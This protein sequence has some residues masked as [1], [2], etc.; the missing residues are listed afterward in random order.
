MK[1][2]VERI[3]IVG[4]ALSFKS[5]ELCVVQRLKHLIKYVFAVNFLGKRF[6]TETVPVLQQAV[7]CRF[8]LGNRASSSTHRTQTFAKT[9][10]LLNTLWKFYLKLGQ[11]DFD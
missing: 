9:T 6:Y 4:A 3:L 8:L 1:I 11:T 2:S 10:T 5:S 7:Y